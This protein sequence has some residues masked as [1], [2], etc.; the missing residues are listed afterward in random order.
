MSKLTR[1]YAE[2]D[3]QLNRTIKRL[4]EKLSL[5]FWMKSKSPVNEMCSHEAYGFFSPEIFE[6]YPYLDRAFVSNGS[7]CLIL[8]CSKMVTFWTRFTFLVNT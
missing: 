5:G 7:K 2:E 1:F 3:P 4:K 6:A 8:R